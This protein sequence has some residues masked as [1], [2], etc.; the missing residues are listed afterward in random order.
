MEPW[1]ANIPLILCE[2]TEDQ[3]VIGTGQSLN[4]GRTIGHL[5]KLPEQC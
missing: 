2:E 5:F 1:K 3:G 4:I